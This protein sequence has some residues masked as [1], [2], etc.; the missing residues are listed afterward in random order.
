MRAT[1]RVKPVPATEQRLREG[2]ADSPELLAIDNLWNAEVALGPD[3]QMFA[4]GTDIPDLDHRGI[5]NLMFDGEIEVH[6]GRNLEIRINAS[7]GQ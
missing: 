3:K 5:T 1:Y 6:H 7:R 4:V 2:R